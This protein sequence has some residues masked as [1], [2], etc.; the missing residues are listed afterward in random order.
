MGA[1]FYL[2]MKQDKPLN[3]YDDINWFCYLIRHGQIKDQ[4][5]VNAYKG[6][7]ITWYHQ[8]LLH[9]PDKFVN[10]GSYPEL[11]NLYQDFINDRPP[12]I[13]D[14]IHPCIFKLKKFFHVS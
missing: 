4:R 11:K 3:S 10:E 6:Q 1:G 9:L 8:L 2:F 12:N 7:I 13:H 5:L 14:Q